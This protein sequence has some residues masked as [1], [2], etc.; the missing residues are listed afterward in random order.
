[1]NRR[2]FLRT[3]SLSGA[4]LATGCATAA[5]GRLPDA[6]WAALP[7]W[8]GFNLLEKFQRDGSN[9]PFVEEDFDLIAEWGFNFVRLPCDYR[10]WTEAPGHY[11]EAPL[12]E[13]D[14]GLAMAR[15]RGIHVLLNLHR[16]PGYTVAKPSEKMNLWSD[17]ADG[18]EARRQFGAQW[19]MFA[20]RYHGI[21]SREL[22][23]NL[24]NEPSKVEAS[25][26]VRA[27][28]A[29]VA[30]IRSADPSRL[31]LADGLEWGSLPGPELAALHIGQCTRGYAPH[32]LSHFRASWVGDTGQWPEPTWPILPKPAPYLYG[33]SKKD[34]QSPLVLRGQFQKSSKFSIHLTKVSYQAQLVVKADGNVI[35]QK[36]Y[37]PAGAKQPTIDDT[38]AAVLPADAREITIAVEHG[39]WL[40]WSEIKIEAAAGYPQKTIHA[41]AGQWGERQEAWLVGNDGQVCPQKQRVECDRNVL[42]TK[43]VEP[44]VKLKE[45]GVGV[46]VGEWGADN[47]APH[48]VVLAWMRDCLANWQRAGFGWALWNLRGSFGVLDSERKDV[49]YENYRGHKLDRQMLELLRTG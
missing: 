2:K 32:T 24:V 46:M 28:T 1:M 25:K 40:V 17:G 7:R 22:S 31:I 42:W 45:S 49:V 48:P 21:P 33:D 43:Y 47:R 26:Y 34:L 18:E 10:I 5:P 12:K 8:R 30:A 20:E 19:Q 37:K 29:A 23:F 39:D 44:W 6:S 13:L 27:C 36:E 38:V 41:A 15:A 35:L 16:A 4:A 14:Q 11:R 3:M 9:Q